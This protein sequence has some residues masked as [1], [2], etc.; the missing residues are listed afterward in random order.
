[1]LAVVVAHS[2]TEGL[3]AKAGAVGVALF[4]TLSGFLI[5]RILLEEQTRTGR[6]S[7]RRFY[8]RRARRLLPALPAA[9]AVCVLSGLAMGTVAVLAPMVSAVTYTSN[10]YTIGRNIGPF[11]HMWSLAVEE[12]FYLVW[13]AIVAVVG[14]RRVLPL[15]VAIGVASAAGRMLLTSSP[16]VQYH[17][18]YFRLDGLLIGAAGAVIVASGWRPR[19]VHVAAGWTI[20]AMFCVPMAPGT[21]ASWGASAVAVASLIVVLGSLDT[22]RA[23]PLLERLGVIGY[24]VYL[25]HYPISLY[26]RT[27]TEFGQTTIFAILLPVSIVLAELSYRLVENRWRSGASNPAAKKTARLDTTWAVTR[28]ARAPKTA[29]NTGSRTL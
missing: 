4:F 19:L 7:L 10:F 29:T 9:V 22:E 11:S 21:L 8:G 15:A 25:F 16:D 26:L 5:T 18:T 24:G 12:H 2:Y 28:P 13:P 3:V 20:L 17:A 27:T 6:I 23:C 1:M 14:Y